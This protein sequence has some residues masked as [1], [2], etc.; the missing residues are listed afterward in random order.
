MHK[1]RTIVDALA[2]IDDP[3]PCSHHID[4]ILEGLSSDY[5]PVVSVIESKSGIM[6]LDEVEILLVAH[7]LRLANFKKSSVPN[8]V[9][10]EP[11]SHI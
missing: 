11:D 8:L 3:L 2:S 10:F 1:I 4:M 9:L 5:A 6:D 7:E